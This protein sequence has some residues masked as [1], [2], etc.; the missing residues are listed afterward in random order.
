M[1]DAHPFTKPAPVG[2]ERLRLARLDELRGAR[3]VQ[4]D[5]EASSP[6]VARGEEVTVETEAREAHH[7][8]ARDAGLL[9]EG[10]CECPESLFCPRR[11]A[12]SHVSPNSGAAGTRSAESRSGPGSRPSAIALRRAR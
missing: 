6:P 2:R 8:R 7:G 11:R 5:D 12:L 9:E 1:R 10:R 3:F 4:L